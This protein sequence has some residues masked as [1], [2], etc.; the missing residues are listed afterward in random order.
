MTL[1]G[2][3]DLYFDNPT[4][5]SNVTKIE[6]A[7]NYLQIASGLDIRVLVR[8]EPAEPDVNGWHHISA[9]RLEAHSKEDK[10][11]RVDPMLKVVR[12]LKSEEERW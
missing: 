5:P 6:A 8:L 2:A 9:M 11:K 3:V 12:E 1:K 4:D 7:I 10:P